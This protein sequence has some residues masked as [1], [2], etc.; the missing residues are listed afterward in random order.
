M[1]MEGE[2]LRVRSA[3]PASEGSRP[4][5]NYAKPAIK[6]VHLKPEEAVLGGCKTNGIVGPTASNCKPLGMCSGQQS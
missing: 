4:R 3:A 1:Y 2:E 6:R 5:R